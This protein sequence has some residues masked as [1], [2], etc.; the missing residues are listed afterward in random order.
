MNEKEW[1][2]VMYAAHSR[3]MQMFY[4]QLNSKWIPVRVDNENDWV[5]VAIHDGRQTR[6]AVF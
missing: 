6:M 4:K 3:T 1:D 5:F 2:E